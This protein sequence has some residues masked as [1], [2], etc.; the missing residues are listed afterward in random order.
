MQP[1]P[2]TDT[3]TVEPG[4]LATSVADNVCAGCGSLASTPCFRCT[5]AADRCHRCGE[6]LHLGECSAWQVNAA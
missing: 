5:P 2:H 1:V 6:A 4:A 3:N